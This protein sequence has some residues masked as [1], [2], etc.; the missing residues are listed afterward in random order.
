MAD[1]T[2]CAAFYCPM[3]GSCGRHENSGAKPDPHY[4]SWG[5]FAPDDNGTSCEYFKPKK[6]GD[7]G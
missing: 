4:Q 1:L 3:S 7:N 5:I 6:G 2:M